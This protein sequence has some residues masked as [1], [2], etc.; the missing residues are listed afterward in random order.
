MTFDVMTRKINAHILEAELAMDMDAFGGW[1]PPAE[2]TPWRAWRPVGAYP[3]D[4]DRRPLVE[5]I[6]PE[7]DFRP[8]D[9]R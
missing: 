2:E 9:E 4:F 5:D 6:G 8:C 1:K 3:T 7:W